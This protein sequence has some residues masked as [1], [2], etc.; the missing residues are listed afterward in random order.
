MSEAAAPAPAPA[1]AGTTTRPPLDEVMLAMDVV[2]TLRRRQRLVERELDVEGREED[3]KERLRK[4]YAA[5]GIE[6]SDQVIEQGVAALKEERFVYKPPPGGL[7]TRL[8]R[9]YVNRGQWGQWV[10]GGLA[11]LILI[12]VGYYFAF[13]APEAALPQEIAARHAQVVQLARSGDARETAERYLNAGKTAL[14]DGDAKAA[15]N[16]LRAL[17]DL[18][19]SLEQ[20][21]TLRIVNRPNERSGVW[22]IP[23]INTGARNFYLIVEAVDSSGKVLTVPIRN[24][25][26]GKTALVDQWGLRVDQRTFEGVARDKQDDGIIAKNRFGY[27]RRGDLAPQYEMPTT[28]GAITEW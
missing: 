2:D 12:G 22:R 13:V 11:A 24:E 21:Y 3:L 25:E 14:R 23:D 10:L 27:K 15:R 5:Q 19:T 6:V 17:T 26:T 18:R 20:E 1:A 4:I 28:G 9:L 7:T 8:A 16:A